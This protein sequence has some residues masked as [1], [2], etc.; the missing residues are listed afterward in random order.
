M[1]YCSTCNSLL[2]GACHQCHSVDLPPG[3]I[4]PT[5]EDDMNAACSAWHKALDN[6]ELLVDQMQRQADLSRD[7]TTAALLC[8]LL[9]LLAWVP[10][11]IALFF[12]LPEAWTV[13]QRIGTAPPGYSCLMAVLVWCLF[14]FIIILVLLLLIL[15]SHTQT[16]P[17]PQG[18]LIF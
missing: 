3:E 2:C 4:C 17:S 5:D 9:S 6:K 7:Y 18:L 15:L 11:L 16:Q 1:Q 8:A 13:K 14:P 10:G 12:I